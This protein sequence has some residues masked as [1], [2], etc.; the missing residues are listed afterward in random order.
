MNSYLTGLASVITELYSR[1]TGAVSTYCFLH[2]SAYL[3]AWFLL[4]PV[5]S[6]RA[7]DAE[8]KAI[9]SLEKLVLTGKVSIERSGD[10]V[11]S[12][13]LNG[14]DISDAV[15][16]HLA[17]FKNLA[18]LIL[19]DTAVTDAGVKDLI[20]HKNLSTLRLG[21]KVTDE[22]LRELSEL[23]KLTD[24][25]LEGT[26]VTDSGLIELAKMKSLTHLNLD[27]TRVTD[28]AF[29]AFV[30]RKPII[31][32]GWPRQ[33]S[34]LLIALASSCSSAS[35]FIKYRDLV[36]E[37]YRVT[38]TFQKAMSD[39]QTQLHNQRESLE[40]APPIVRRLLLMSRFLQVTPVIEQTPLYDLM[41]IM[42]LAD[43][44]MAAESLE[45]LR[46]KLHWYGIYL[47]WPPYHTALRHIDPF[48]RY[49]Q[50]LLELRRDLEFGRTNTN[51]R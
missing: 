44:A 35:S 46:F 47:K 7:D 1:L 29:K 32:T 49:L 11:T 5:A 12:V 31:L 43:P 6:V 17:P 51:K 10:T 3:T 40:N 9:A 33:R 48:F 21:S 41:L 19:Y 2:A 27:G 37:R 16:K 26:K 13:F 18:T 38:A 22:G 36:V 4:A 14:E 8:D 50:V 34:N 24:L 20:Q 45:L 28:A 25:D 23:K 39:R 30:A 15:L 42:Q